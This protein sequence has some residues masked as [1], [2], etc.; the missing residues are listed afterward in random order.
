MEPQR[1]VSRGFDLTPDLLTTQGR[2]L[3][4][5]ALSLLG[6]AH[7]AEDVVQETWLTCLRHP[8]A[9][10]ERVS[11]WLGTVTKHLA[12]HRLRGDGRRA[13]RERRMAE[14]ERLEALQQRTLERE[15]ALRAVTQALLALEEPLKTTLLLRYYED[16]SPATI[17]AELGVPLATVKSRLARGLERL[18]AKLA[19]EFARAGHEDAEARQTRALSALAGLRSP[20]LAIGN[21]SAAGPTAAAAST[22]GTLALAS[23]LQLAAAALA[24]VGGSVWWWNRAQE[25]RSERAGAAPA[26]AASPAVAVLGPDGSGDSEPLVARSS[27]VGG[28]RRESLVADEPEPEAALALAPEAA[29]LYRVTGQIRDELDLPLPG[30]RVF[31]GPHRFP[32]NHM[33]STDETGRFTLEFAGRRPSFD[34]AFTVDDGGGRVLGLRELHL[35]SGQELVVDVGLGPISSRGTALV[36]LSNAAVT[37]SMDERD[38]A[39]ASGIHFSFEGA[40][41]RPMRAAASIRVSSY[42]RTFGYGSAPLERA[43]AAAR[44]RDGR[45]LF[46]DPPPSGACSRLQ[47]A[48]ELETVEIAANHLREGLSLAPVYG[49]YKRVFVFEGALPAVEPEADSTLRGVVRDAFGNPVPG[50][51]IRWALPGGAFEKRVSSD[52]DGNFEL[53][54]VAPGEVVVRAGGGDLGRAR[55]NLTLAP[56]QDGT[57][58][59]VLE[60]GDEVTGR[61][62][63]Q[64]GARPLSGVLVELWSVSPTF[65]WCDST[66]TDGDG[67]FA[68]PN[69]PSGALELHVYASG[70]MDPP[71]AFPIRVVRPVFAPGDVGDILLA[72]QDPVT[73][74][75]ALTVLGPDSDPLPG[76]EVRVW[77]DSTGRGCF[78]GEPDETGKHAL[79]GLPHGSYRVEVGGPFGWRELGTIWV[80]EDLEL[81]PEHFAPAGLAQIEGVPAGSTLR[82]SLWSAHPDVFGLV[83]GQELGC[84]TLMLRAGDYVLCASDEERRLETALAVKAGSVNALALEASSSNTI[85]VQPRT[86]APA[87]EAGARDTN[88]SACHVSGQSGG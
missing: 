5:L 47:T 85:T 64:E 44:G 69:V 6:D 60:R 4:G 8:G 22:V 16:R 48:F 15:E 35:V 21:G 71:S 13:L 62:V 53:L 12:L 34:C 39:E 46:V 43:P 7:A 19:A 3:R 24:L 70:L 52:E 56:D 83:E 14:P 86:L 55:A 18:R 26:T 9:L 23:K 2:A 1:P 57:W 27:G 45:L 17:A 66:L 76:S 79:A 36:D 51:E 42:V 38:E 29:F 77:Q 61:V 75:L 40:H 74:S 49:V 81:A 87:L 68:V 10:P 11:A 28:A 82:A 88:C 50:A 73:S 20:G 84:V 80:D 33:A 78:A 58:N 31:L 25:E 72:A 63:L 67:R 41:Q 65:L 59:P 54:G 37:P 30:A 32:L